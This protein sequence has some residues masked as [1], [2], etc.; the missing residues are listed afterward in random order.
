VA[1][2]DTTTTVLL[3]GGGVTATAVDAVGRVT[4]PVPEGH[5]RYQVALSYG[6]S[7]GQVLPTDSVVVG[8]FDGSRLAVS[9]LVLSRERRGAVWVPAPGDTAY[10]NPRTTWSRPDTLALYHEIYG[11]GAGTPYQEKLVLRRGKRT[12]LSLGWEGTAGEVT[13]VT[14]T[15]SFERVRAGDYVLEM[16]VV[17]TDGARATTRRAIRITKNDR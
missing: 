14:R 5:W 16:E 12:E 1:W 10:F 13:R 3:P 6:D 4:L 17:R 11:L 15:I 2:V 8:Q 7:T 9:D